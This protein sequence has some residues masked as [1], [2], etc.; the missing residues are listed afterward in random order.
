MDSR[1]FIGSTIF[2][3]QQQEKGQLWPNSYYRDSSR[4]LCP[5]RSAYQKLCSSEFKLSAQMK[6]SIE[7]FL[8][9]SIADINDKR[10]NYLLKCIQN[11]QD[12]GHRLGKIGQQKVKRSFLLI[13]VIRKIKD[14][15]RCTRY[16][17]KNVCNKRN[18]VNK[19]EYSE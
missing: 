19:L 15:I 16:M 14:Y 13:D 12:V 1:H 10:L 7:N 3:R 17:A 9:T 6:C 18:I 8:C 11:V 5:C 2:C 4:Y